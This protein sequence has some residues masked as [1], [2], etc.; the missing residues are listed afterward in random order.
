MGTLKHVAII[1]EPNTPLPNICRD[2]DDN[3]ILQ[4]A[5]T[6]NANFIVTGDKDLLTLAVFGSTKIVSPAVFMQTE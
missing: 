5:E 3:N 1:V 2:P 4:L 6:A